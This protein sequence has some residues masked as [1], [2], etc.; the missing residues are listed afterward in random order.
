MYYVW[1]PN[2]RKI[3]IYVENLEVRHNYLD[4]EGRNT[5]RNF[6]LEYPLMH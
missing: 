3:E 5:K 1:L 4:V 6:K 2:G